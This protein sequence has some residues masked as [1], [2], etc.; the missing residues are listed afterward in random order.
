MP[1]CPGSHLTLCSWS[2]SLP[3][4]SNGPHPAIVVSSCL[5]EPKLVRTCV[6]TEASGPELFRFVED[7]PYEEPKEPFVTV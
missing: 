3:P 2:R 6:G 4:G 1:G 5:G 7:V